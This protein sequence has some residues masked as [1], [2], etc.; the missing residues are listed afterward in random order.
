MS[1][2]LEVIDC[3]GRKVV[4]DHSNWE[5]HIAARRHL[6]V[7]EYHDRFAEVLRDPDIV[8]EARRDKHH[9]FF[10]QGITRGRHARL[11]LLVVVAEFAGV[12]KVT[13]WRLVPFVDTEGAVIWTR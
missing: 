13:T 10:R 5:K 1:C 7:V 3:F 6:E 4:L 9:H 12:H 8:V 2:E 11:Y